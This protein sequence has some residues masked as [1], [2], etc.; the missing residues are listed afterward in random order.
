MTKWPPPRP[1]TLPA[2]LRLKPEELDTF[3]V[4]AHPESD[5]CPGDKD[6]AGTHNY[7]L[8]IKVCI[9]GEKMGPLGAPAARGTDNHGNVIHHVPDSR[10][11]YEVKK[12]TTT[13]VDNV[14]KVT[15]LE[16]GI[17]H[18]TGHG[19]GVLIKGAP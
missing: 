15:R 8:T 12:N 7:K 2:R 9:V 6:S 13:E 14:G 18:D 5:S 3:H 19:I 1:S 11:F 17:E 16:R 10:R 4:L